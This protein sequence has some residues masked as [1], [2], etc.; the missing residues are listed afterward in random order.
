M[1]VRPTWDLYFLRIADAVAGRA[2]CTR[3][4]VGCVIV[5][6]DHRILASGYNGSPPGGPSC[7][8]GQCPRG[9]KTYEQQPG[10]VGSYDDCHA[11]HAELNAII[12][13]R[14]SCKGATIYITDPPCPGCAKAIR[15]A[16]IT[17]VV[18]P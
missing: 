6:Q 15:S 12:F 17:R 14:G 2:D 11:T 9:T 5:D 18:H 10:L 3:R 8:N 1:N 13:A 7:L 4:R 16:G